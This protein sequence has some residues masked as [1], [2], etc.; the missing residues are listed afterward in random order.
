MPPLVWKDEVALVANGDERGRG[1]GSAQNEAEGGRPRVE[2]WP[3][4]ARKPRRRGR[5]CRSRTQLDRSTRRGGLIEGAAGGGYPSDRAL[6]W[7]QSRTRRGLGVEATRWW[8]YQNGCSR[9]MPKDGCAWVEDFAHRDGRV[10]NRARWGRGV[11][12]ARGLGPSDPL[13]V[14]ARL[15]LRLECRSEELQRRVGAADGADWRN[16]SGGA[17][18]GRRRVAGK[19][20]RACRGHVV[21]CGVPREV[22]VVRV[23]QRRD[24]SG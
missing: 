9:G 13:L 24:C 3:A 15:C 7:R 4:V 6:I 10:F 14:G 5:W 17:M 2:V 20:G 22:L 8:F 23:A 18:R 19:N 16:R 1:E 12:G 21:R 11:S